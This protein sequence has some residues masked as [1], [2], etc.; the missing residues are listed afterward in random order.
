M[1]LTVK[2]SRLAKVDDFQTVDHAVSPFVH[3]GLSLIWLQVWR[4]AYGRTRD[5]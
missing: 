4:D 2:L 5:T 3:Q 1:T